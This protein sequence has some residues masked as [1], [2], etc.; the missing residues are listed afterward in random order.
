VTRRSAAGLAAAGSAAAFVTALYLRLNAAYGPFN[1][2]WNP[3]DWTVL[4][5]LWRHG[6]IARDV[7]GQAVVLG[8]A[9]AALPWAIFWSWSRRRRSG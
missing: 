6:Q 3:A 4:W 7:A 8:A 1:L 5:E 2:S 9:A